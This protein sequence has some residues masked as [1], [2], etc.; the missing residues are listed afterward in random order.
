M[1]KIHL[2]DGGHFDFS[3]PEQSVYTV[4]DIARNLSHINRFTGSTEEIFIT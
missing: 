2:V 3:N 1:T 4:K